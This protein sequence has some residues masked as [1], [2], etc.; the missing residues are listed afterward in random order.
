MANQIIQR[1]Y[2]NHPEPNHELKNVLTVEQF[3]DLLVEEE[4]YFP[5]EQH[6]TK[7]MISRLRKIFY[8]QWGWNTELIKGATHIEGRYDVIIVED[9]TEHTKE[10]KRYKQFNYAPKHRSV[11]YKKND[12]VYGDT[13]AGQPTFIYS[14]DHQEVVLPDGNYCDIAHILAGLD[15]CNHPQVVTPLPGFLSF[16]YK[17]FPYV[18]FNMDMATW[19]GDVGSASG[20]FLFYYLLNS[21]TA[22]INMQQYYIDVNNPGSDLLGNID[23]YVIRDSYEVGSENGERFTDILKDYYLTD[24]AFRKKRVTIFC[25]SVGLGEYADGKF[26]NEANWTRYYSKQLLNETSF[27]VFSVTDEKIHSIWLPLAVW[28]GFY[29]KQLKTKPLLINFIEAL[30]REVIKEK[31]LSPIA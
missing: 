23:T 30:K 29:Q 9:G 12:R 14:Y 17:L 20:D 22:D 5:G 7:L 28:F 18:G 3:I 16:M 15:A 13:R 4:D 31:E 10:I 25:K 11:V 24:N 6:N 2:A 26:S 1:V 27:Q 8:D 19:L 21:K